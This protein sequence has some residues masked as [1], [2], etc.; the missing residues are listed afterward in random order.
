MTVPKKILGLIFVVFAASPSFSQTTWNGNGNG[1]FWDDD[2]NWTNLSPSSS[3]GAVFNTATG[4]TGYSVDFT[5]AS[6]TFNSGV[7]VGDKIT[8]LA[9]ATLTVNGAIT[10]NTSNLQILNTVVNAGA[11]STWT[12]PIQYSNIVNIGVRQ[13]TLA[14]AHTFSG[15]NINFDITNLSTYGKFLGSFTSSITNVTSINI[16]SGSYV[17]SAGDTFDF[18]TSSF[19][20]AKMGTLPTLT[21]GMTWNTSNF[22]SSGVLTVVAAIP[23]PS[24]YATLF[25]AVAIGFSVWRKRRKA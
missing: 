4:E 9:G 1:A 12:G 13:I 3:S 7:G 10:N 20:T 14:G 11:N 8:G 21:G 16:N 5:I 15:A 17:F 6:L 18:T 2:A 25:G 23:E 24:T 22:I 19:G